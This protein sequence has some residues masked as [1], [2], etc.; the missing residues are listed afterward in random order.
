[1]TRAMILAA[2]LGTRLRPLT[3]ELPK[4]LVWVGDRPMVAHV[5]EQLA[6]GG[7]R[8]AVLNAHHRAGDFSGGALAGLPIAIEIV[9]EAQ[10]LGTAGGV[11]NASRALGEGDVVV[12][13][14]DILMELDV[15]A[16]LA[17]HAGAGE[18]ATL[19]VSP[20]GVGEGTVGV[21]A[22]GRV[23]RL[24]GGDSCSSDIA[25]MILRRA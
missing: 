10:I 9:H 15:R 2:G 21:D 7:I 5:A 23:V 4:P 22:R 24:R 1:M 20:R 17:A 8:E 25:H 19:A 18:G 14:G 12:W 6:A 11:A 3:D 16:L 13:N